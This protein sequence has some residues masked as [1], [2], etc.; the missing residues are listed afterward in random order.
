MINNKKVVAIIPARG[1]SKRLPKKNIKKFL[2][3][4]LLSWTIRAAQESKFIDKIILS[5]EDE[6]ILKI[7]R[8]YGSE[9]PLKRPKNLAYDN[10]ES[11]EVIKY[12]LDKIGN[13]FFYI[14]LLQPTSP[15][16]TNKDI[17]NCIKEF[18]KKKST[19]CV[20]A[21]KFHKSLNIFIEKKSNTIGNVFSDKNKPNKYYVLN[22]AI[23]LT[24]KYTLMRNKG[25]ISDNTLLFEM[26]LSKSIDIDTIDDFEIAEFFGKK[27][28][29]KFKD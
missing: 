17:D 1:G 25:F 9:I 7:A 21:F 20:S 12:V 22:G 8:S 15:L 4:P 29:I 13:D 14:I 11:F 10:S 28:N 23:Y 3:Y 18:I 27:I 16:R 5:S 2:G 6:S 19:S 24:D 26:P